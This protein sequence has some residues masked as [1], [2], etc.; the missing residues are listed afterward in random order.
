MEFSNAFA[1]MK[2]GHKMKL[3]S[4]GGF[5]FWDNEK[6]TI[7]MQC[8]KVDSDTGKD[9]LDIRETQRVEYTLQNMMSDDWIE[10]TA[11]NCTVLGGTPLFGFE[12]AIKYVKRGMAVKRAGWNG[13]DQYIA[14][15]ENV[16]CKRPDSDTFCANHK[17]IGSKAIA[18]FGTRGVQIGWL[19]SQSDMLA[20]D[21]MFA[22]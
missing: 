6:K 12:E 20:N 16:Y 8:R 9:L 4:W 3:P 10:A 2:Q 15:V 1:L 11:E 17:D 22:E 21:W 13:K 7:M 19:A 18:F 5:W 14:M